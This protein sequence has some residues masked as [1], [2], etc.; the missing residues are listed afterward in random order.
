MFVN[1][2]RNVY[3]L[4]CFFLFSTRPPPGLLPV[5]GPLGRGTDATHQPGPAL[6]LLGCWGSRVERWLTANACKQC[7]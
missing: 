1:K 3:M 2:I 7:S 5:L 4:K 6:R